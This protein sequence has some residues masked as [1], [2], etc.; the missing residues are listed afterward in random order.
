[1]SV[2]VAILPFVRPGIAGL[3]RVHEPTD[4]IEIQIFK[5]TFLRGARHH[6]LHLVMA[7]DV[8]SLHHIDHKHT[9]RFDGW[10]TLISLSDRKSNRDPHI[11]FSFVHRNPMLI[12]RAL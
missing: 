10:Q 11:F 1:M 12:V 6:E 3:T 4:V 5:F 9:Y 8:I 7:T 2:N